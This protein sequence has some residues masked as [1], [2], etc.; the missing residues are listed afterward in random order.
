MAESPAIFLVILRWLHAVAAGLWLGGGLLVIALRKRGLETD[1]APSVWGRAAG[2]TLRLGV[3]VFILTGTLLATSRLTEPNVPGAYV[4]ILAVKIALAFLMFGLAV[5]RSRNNAPSSQQPRRELLRDRTF[6][7]VAIGLFIYLISVALD[8][9]VERA[10][11]QM[12]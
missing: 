2:H 7:I 6:W 8:E 10:A 9:L 11:L 3:A 5:P 4:A 1:L 12:G